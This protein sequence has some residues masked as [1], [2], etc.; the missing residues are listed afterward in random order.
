MV[1][2]FTLTVASI[3]GLVVTVLSTPLGR[4]KVRMYIAKYYL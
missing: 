1:N 2:I 3:A 4:S